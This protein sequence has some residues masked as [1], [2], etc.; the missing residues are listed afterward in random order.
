VDD[1]FGRALLFLRE[2]RNRTPGFT[3]GALKWYQRGDFQFVNWIMAFLKRVTRGSPQP[4]SFS[5]HAQQALA[6]SGEEAKRLNH[7]FVGTEHL[8]LGL[9]SLGQGIAVTALQNLGLTL[10]TVRMEVEKQVGLGPSV[11]MIGNVPY[12]PRVKKVLA[13]A[14]K[15][16]ARLNHTHVGTEHIL[17]GLL[18]EGDG[19]A[20]RVLK[21]LGL[22]VNETRAEVLRLLEPNPPITAESTK[23]SKIPQN[24]NFKK[25][26]PDPIDV[27][28]RYDVYCA[29]INGIVVYR[30]ALFKGRKKL[31][32]MREH[33]FGAEFIELEQSNGQT[34][35]VSLNAVRK[36]CEPDVK[37][38]GEL[39][40]RIK[41]ET[42]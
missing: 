11:T 8:L 6:L 29:E 33:D 5:P 17:L 30:N 15:E 40:S 3:S 16:A 34:V 25:S 26:Q 21:N 7:N 19:V 20:A 18:L 27:T 39:L 1:G 38:V 14:A 28:K 35:Y 9:I 22:N 42:P 41:P 23:P 37:I 32:S 13:L 10:D 36:F 4:S 24:M 31:L 12:T 2:A